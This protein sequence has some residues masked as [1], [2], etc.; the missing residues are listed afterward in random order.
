MILLLHNFLNF[1]MVIYIYIYIKFMIFFISC[2]LYTFELIYI[3]KINTT[4]TFELIYIIKINTT[5]ISI[6]MVKLYVT[7]QIHH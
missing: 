7:T 4:I 5:I 3:I 2:K 1:H 6:H